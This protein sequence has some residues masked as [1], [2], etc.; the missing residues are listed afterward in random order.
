LITKQTCRAVGYREK[1]F[2]LLEMLL[3]VA[4]L[5]VM[6]LIIVPNFGWFTGHGETEA[7]AVEERLLKTATIAHATINGAC[8]TSID[9]LAPYVGNP[10]DIKG[11]YSF[12]GTYP[13]CTA[14]QDSCP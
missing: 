4:I 6:A 10:D 1:G 14:S 8:P 9:D 11:S 13:D 3:V 7:C 5:G 12:G 2:T